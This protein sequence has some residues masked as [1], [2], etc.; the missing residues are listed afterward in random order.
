MAKAFSHAGGAGVR[1]R[2]CGGLAGGGRISLFK[3]VLLA[4]LAG[5][6]ALWGG[7][8]QAQ[9]SA[10]EVVRGTNWLVAQI[11]ANGALTNE[12]G[13]MA[14]VFQNRSE[15]A[16]TLKLLASVPTSLSDI[17]A[18]DNDGSTEYLARKI[19]SLAQAGRSV[20]PYLPI[21]AQRQNGN[22]GF[23]GGQG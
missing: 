17:I 21:L 2:G 13:S 15:A 14:T 5:L 11:Q 19:I 4:C 18:A 1:G 8:V 12:P 16:V 9:A 23:G 6:L 20:S 10:P 3:S 7:A 22:G